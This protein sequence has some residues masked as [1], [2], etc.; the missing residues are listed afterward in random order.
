[1]RTLDEHVGRP[2]RPGTVPRPEHRGEEFI[3]V[4]EV[5]DRH[6]PAVGALGAEVEDVRPERADTLRDL[7]VAPVLGVR[8]DVLDL[9]ALLLLEP[10]GDREDGDRLPDPALPECVVLLE[11]G[12]ARVDDADLHAAAPGGGPGIL[13][14]AS[15]SREFVAVEEV[16]RETR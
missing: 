11:D 15:G 1:V 2:R 8:V 13:S 16:V 7:G 14:R 10:G 9:P 6:L 5:G 12:D 3:H 4:G